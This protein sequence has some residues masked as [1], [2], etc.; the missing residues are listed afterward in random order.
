[1]NY[2]VR[3]NVRIE[4]VVGPE[5]D[6]GWLVNTFQLKSFLKTTVSLFSRE[7]IVND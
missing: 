3:A 6:S 4:S 2:I 7:K 5:A 1:M